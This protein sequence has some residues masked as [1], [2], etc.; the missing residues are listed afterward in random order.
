MKKGYVDTTR[1]QVHYCREG[2]NGPDLFLLHGTPL[3]SREFERCIPIFGRSTRVVAFDTPGYGASDP[4]DAPTTVEVYAAWLLDAIDAI[5]GKEFA[6]GGIHTGAAIA[7][8][9]IRQAGKRVTHAIFSGFPLMTGDEKKKAAER[10]G[11][12]AAQE[13]GGHLARMW[14][15]R[16]E[17]WGKETSL[18]YLQMA[19]SDTMRIYDRHDWGAKAVFA[20]D[21]VPALKELKC[22]VLFLNADGDRLAEADTKA[23]ELVAGSVLKI[24]PDVA[25]Q[26]PWRAPEIYAREIFEFIGAP[27]PSMRVGRT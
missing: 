9:L 27:M 7:V 25:G 15:L 19:A 26:L 12:P 13:D 22:P 14:R 20:H 18:G 10:L 24:V 6:L 23:A 1:G 5:G 17:S 2:D 16:T 21:C 3:S 8:E 11:E 4:P